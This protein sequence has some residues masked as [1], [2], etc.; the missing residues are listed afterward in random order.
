[1]SFR[2]ILFHKPYGVLCQFSGV[3]PTLADFD[4]P[5][6]IYA[7]GRL[8]KDS[9]GLLLLTNDGIFNQKLTHP[10]SNKEKIYQV[11]VDGTPSS[12]D[13]KKLETG[14]LIKGKKARAKKAILLKTP[15]HFPNG[16]TIRER[17]NIPTTWIELTLTQGLNRQVRRMTAQIGHPTLRLIRT[18]L[19]PYQLKDLPAGKWVETDRQ[20]L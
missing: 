17:K 11:L 16:P 5:K 7:A 1:M 8:D 4:L 9:E 6:G 15:I 18:G 12:E 20:K 19:G 14:V 13:L 2:Y 10:K 3:G